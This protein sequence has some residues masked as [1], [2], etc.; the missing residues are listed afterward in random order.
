MG[1]TAIRRCPRYWVFLTGFAARANFYVGFS[2]H[3]VIF[4]FGCPGLLFVG[5]LGGVFRIAPGFLHLA[6]GLFHCSLNLFFRISGPF[7]R[8]TLDAASNVL[9]LAF[10]LIFVHEYSSGMICARN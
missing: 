2:P 9:G 10:H 3:G 1:I 7:S 5:F 4:R 6:L 8:L